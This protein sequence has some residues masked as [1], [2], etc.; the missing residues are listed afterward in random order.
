M[1][2]E[3]DAWWA[4]CPCQP[5]S[6][7]GDREGAADERDGYPATLAL[8]AKHR[9]RWAIL[10]NVR[11]LLTHSKEFHPDPKRCPGC[12]FEGIL[13]RLRTLFAVV[14]YRVLCAADYGVPQTRHRVIVVCGPVA[15]DWPAPTHSSA[16]LDEVKADGRYWS[17]CEAQDWTRDLGGGADGLRPWETMRRALRLPLPLGRVH[18]VARADVPAAV[19][20]EASNDVGC[21]VL[22]IFRRVCCRWRR[23]RRGGVGLDVS[24]GCDSAA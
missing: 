10:E 17:A 1:L 20:V 23:G 3:A 13:A 6:S 21:V 24:P 22:R 8:F 19:H 9:P 15:I 4:S 16:T 7:A 12:Y 11:G 5:F 18:A 2:P 14:E